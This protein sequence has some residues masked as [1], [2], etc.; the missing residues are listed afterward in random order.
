[1][2]EQLHAWADAYEACEEYNSI[3]TRDLVDAWGEENYRTWIG[4]LSHAELGNAL[5][6]MVPALLAHLY[7]QQEL[8]RVYRN[9]LRHTIREITRSGD[10]IVQATGEA[11]ALGVDQPPGVRDEPDDEAVRLK[12]IMAQ[13]EERVRQ[14]LRPPIGGGRISERNRG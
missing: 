4:F 12:V 13:I 5:V 11:L 10:T 1:M 7:R 2:I 8:E 9:A 14:Q 3:P 6:E